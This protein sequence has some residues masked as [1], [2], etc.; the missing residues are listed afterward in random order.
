M[1]GN[2]HAGC[3]KR[4]RNGPVDETGTAPR[5]DFTVNTIFLKRVYVLFVMEVRTVTVSPGQE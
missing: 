4:P 1:P 5:A 3:G 2:R